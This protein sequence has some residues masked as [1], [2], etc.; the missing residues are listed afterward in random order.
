LEESLNYEDYKDNC[1]NLQGYKTVCNQ[2]EQRIT[3]LWQKAS[4]KI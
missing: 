4:P 1:K 2:F 3:E